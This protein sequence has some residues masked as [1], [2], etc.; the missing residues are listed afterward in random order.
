LRKTVYT[1]VVDGYD[2]IGAPLIVEGATDYIVFSDD[3]DLAVPS[4]WQ[5]RPILRRERNPRMTARWHKLHPHRLFPESDVSVY[6]D[7]NILL[8]AALSP[9]LARMLAGAPIAVFRHP[10]RD[11]P[12]AEAEVVRRHRL[13]EAAVVTAQVAYYRSKGFAAKGG[14]H[15]SGVLLRR[16]NDP[17]LVPFHED[18]WRQLKVFSH[19][20]QISLDFMLQ[21]HGIAPAEIPGLLA[22]SPW[23][24]VAP[25]RR[26][27]VH[28]VDSRELAQADELDWLR[29]ALIAEGRALQSPA[30]LAGVLD[31]LRWHM[32]EPLRRAKRHF[33]MLTWRPPAD[34]APQAETA[35]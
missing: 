16:H 35:P 21:R 34:A 26:F 17:R 13:D 9:L 20:D 19:R 6:I 25:H 33:I 11:C 24:A 30:T 4:P 3:S 2:R 27:C 28:R 7:S 1:C 14:L 29:L 15:N 8:R 23:F 31:S 5:L 22:H 32:M 12:Y 10:E 18:W